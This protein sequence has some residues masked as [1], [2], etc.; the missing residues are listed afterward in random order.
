M[1]RVGDV[2][3]MLS[4]RV[5]A[6]GKEYQKGKYHVFVC[7]SP[8]VYFFIN[9]EAKFCDSFEITHADFPDLPNERSFVGCGNP[10]KI[11]DTE[12]RRCHARCIGRLPK[13]VLY[14]LLD[15][16]ARADGLTEDERDLICDAIAAELGYEQ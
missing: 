14:D 4:R 6:G 15:H 7:A 8:R 1:F 9:S 13:S 3:W 5:V 16:V 10:L 2:V 11:P 12:A